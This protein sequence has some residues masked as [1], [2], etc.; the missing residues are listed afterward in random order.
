MPKPPSG[1]D[2]DARRR[3]RPRRSGRSRGNPDRGVGSISSVTERG[4]RCSGTTAP[5]T[6]T[7]CCRRRSRWS[8]RRPR[9][10]G[11]PAALAALAACAIGPSWKNGSSRYGDVVDDHGRVIDRAQP[12]D[13]VGEVEVA[14]VGGREREMR[15]RREAVRELDHRAA[16]RRSA[17]RRRSR[18]C[19]FTGVVKPHGLAG[20]GRSPDADVGGRTRRR[21][22]VMLKESDRTPIV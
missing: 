21:V 14:V 9:S 13:L 11:T 6:T 19:T 22:R 7:R 16:L 4:T 2:R 12:R 1:C 20:P 17:R 5:R 18:T 3:C 10:T 15:S 8:C